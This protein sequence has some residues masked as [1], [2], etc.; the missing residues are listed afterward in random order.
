MNNPPRIDPEFKDLIPPLSQEEYRQLEENILANQCRDPIVL[1]RGIIIDGHNRHEICT[2]HSLPYKTVKLR[3]PSR[4]AAKLWILENQLGRRN[5]TDATRI[6]IATRK[7][8]YQKT[9]AN[10]AIAKAAR[11]SEKTVWHFMRI[12]AKGGPELVEK[13]MSGQLKINTA[14]RRLKT[15]DQL[16]VTIT[17]IENLCP[18]HTPAP[19]SQERTISLIMDNI[20]QLQNIYAFLIRYEGIGPHTPEIVLEGLERHYRAVGKMVSDIVG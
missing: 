6:A 1:W 13:L 4:E 9:Y 10:K 15:A 19:S 17:K 18:S 14:A 20:R 12:K 11:V 8:E 3:L 2:K 16:D 5:L 7:L